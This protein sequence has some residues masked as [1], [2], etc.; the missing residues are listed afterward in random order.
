MG[1]WGSEVQ[2]LSPRPHAVFLYGKAAFFLVRLRLR[3]VS[4][5]RALRS[6][7][8]KDRALLHD[9]ETVTAEN[10]D[11]LIAMLAVARLQHE[12][13]FDLL[14]GRAGRHAMMRD[15]Q[16]IDILLGHHR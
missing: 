4:L 9:I 2:I 14:D 5:S 6:A 10:R 7:H 13:D 12:R 11:Q 15:I 8:I 3:L 1:L 16:H